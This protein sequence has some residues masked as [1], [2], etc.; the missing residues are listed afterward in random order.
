[1]ADD[2][3]IEEAAAIMF[4]ASLAFTNTIGRKWWAWDACDE[5]TKQY[6]RNIAKHVWIVFNRSS[7]T[8]P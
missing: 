5:R 1:M 8:V 7:K 6:W 4:A 2:K 3:Q